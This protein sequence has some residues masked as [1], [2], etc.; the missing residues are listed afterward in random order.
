M[1]LHARNHNTTSGFT[2]AAEKYD[3]APGALR[4]DFSDLSEIG[5]PSPEIR[6]YLVP[7]DFVVG[8]D[9]P[10]PKGGL[11]ARIP[12]LEEIRNDRFLTDLH[13]EVI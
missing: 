2:A 6:E 1:K 4:L 5:D 10:L 12:W 11:P 9:G 3:D 7:L 8:H 13:S